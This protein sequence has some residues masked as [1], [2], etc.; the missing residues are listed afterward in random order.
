MKDDSIPLSKLVAT[1]WEAH[2]NK[3]TGIMFLSTQDNHPVQINFYEGIIGSIQLSNKQNEE[4]LTI[5]RST[6][7][8]RFQQIKAPIKP[9]N[10]VFKD[11]P[12]IIKSLDIP[13]QSSSSPNFM[14][15]SLSNE[16]KEFLQ[17]ELTN[18]LGPIAAIISKDILSREIT[19]KSAIALLSNEIPDKKEADNF[20]KI[21]LN[22]LTD[23]SIND[24]Q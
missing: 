4:A 19:L 22:H 11:T 24:L 10:K 5:L 18:F 15:T 12:D 3:F 21:V 14:K 16:S 17:Q 23:A 8:Y 6:K 2:N 20:K 7:L 1:L 9:K 13:D